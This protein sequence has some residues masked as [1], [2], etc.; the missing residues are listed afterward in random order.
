[1]ASQHARPYA[2]DAFHRYVIEEEDATN[3]ARL[4]TKSCVHYRYVVPT[5]GSVALRMRLNPETLDAPL[6]DVDAVLQERLAEADQFYATIHP[7]AASDDERLVQRQAF[8]GLL[9]TKQI[10][11][12]DVNQWLEGD[13]VHRPLP[14]SRR[15]VR[16]ASGDTSTRC[17]SSPCR[18]SGSSPGSRPGT[19][20][21]RLAAGLVDP[22]F[23]KEQLWVLLFEQFLH[24][25]GQIPA[26]EWE[27]STSTRPSTP[28]RS[29]VSAPWT[30]TAPDGR[31]GVS[32]EVLSQAADQLHVVGEQGR[33]AGNNIFQGGFLGLDN[34][35]VVDRGGRCPT[36]RSSSSPMQRAGWRCS[37]S[38]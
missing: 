10:Y 15:F 13:A 36:G 2:K 23:A 1:M 14:E 37:V 12:F 11:L 17:A 35:A 27:F 24:P 30:G 32:R 9:W 21:P 26:Y 6:R 18:T 34:I 7:P 28:G 29:G 8:A 38:T 3:P 4:G 25:S 20:L 19:G 5:G 16:T 31:P 33:P 22:E